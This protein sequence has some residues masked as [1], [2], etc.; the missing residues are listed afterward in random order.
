[1]VVNAKIKTVD[2][3]AI[4]KYSIAHLWVLDSLPVRFVYKK[5]RF[6][7]DI[8]HM[9]WST[10]V[11]AQPYSSDYR[12]ILAL[13]EVITGYPANYINKLP[14][15][16]TYPLFRYYNRKYRSIME[17]LNN[18]NDMIPQKKEP[19][20]DMNKFG[21]SNI[22]DFLA[23]AKNIEIDKI[24]DWSLAKVLSEYDREVRHV[25]NQQKAMERKK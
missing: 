13:I 8:I 24:D 23:K 1:M 16:I 3:L 4:L 11:E 21:L 18:I 22:T 6:P 25:I 5:R 10:F 19:A 17:A 2:L 12:N 14:I 15:Y 7:E 9:K 20:K